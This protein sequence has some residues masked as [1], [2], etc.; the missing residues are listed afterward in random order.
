MQGASTFAVDLSAHGI[1]NAWF[2]R[3]L[4]LNG[5]LI[6]VLQPFL[7]PVLARH[8]RSRTLAAGAVLV[9]IG[10]GVNALA[11]SLPWYALGV[12][13]WTLGEIMALPMANALVADLA[14]ADVRARYQGAFGLSFSLAVCAAPALG[15]AALERFGSAAL[16][17]GCLATGLLVAAGHLALRRALT[18]T[19]RSRMA[20]ATDGR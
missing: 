16:W 14:P 15:M 9:G 4:A 12:L 1:S 7:G 5:L 10:F 13:V 19:R 11:R 20:A 6:M 17:L 8:N 18:A 3:V 2:G